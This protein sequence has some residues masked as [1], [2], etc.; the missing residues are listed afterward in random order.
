MPNR[1]RYTFVHDSK[2]VDVVVPEY[3]AG[4]LSERSAW[5]TLLLA[6]SGAALAHI[7]LRRLENQLDAGWLDVIGGA[8]WWLSALVALPFGFLRQRIG[9]WF[10]DQA[11]RRFLNTG[12]WPSGA[13][14]K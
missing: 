6:A 2:L 11:S 14:G 9:W 10:L 8:V 7:A 13:W 1:I 3:L 12:E 5:I 4:R